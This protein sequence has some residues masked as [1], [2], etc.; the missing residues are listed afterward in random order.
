MTMKVYDMT[1]PKM[2][3]LVEYGTSPVWSLYYTSETGKGKEVQFH[4]L[5]QAK[6][7]ATRNEMRIVFLETRKAQ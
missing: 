3:I 5:G 1:D 6:A 2:A 4:D 7:F